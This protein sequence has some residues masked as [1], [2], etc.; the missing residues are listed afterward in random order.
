MQNVHPSESNKSLQQNGDDLLESALNKKIIDAEGYLAIVRLLIVAANIFAIALFFDQDNYKFWVVWP[1]IVVAS[2][3]STY[4]FVFKPY[5]RFEVLRSS[6]FATFSDGALITLLL[7]STGGAESP[8]FILW[9]I[10]LIAVAMRFSLKETVLTTLL[11]LCAD[12]AI[13]LLDTEKDLNIAALMVRFLYLPIFGVLGV[14]ISKEVHNQLNDKVKIAKTESDLK[15]VNDELEQRV[16]RRTHELEET[17]KDILDSITYAKR[18]QNAMLPSRAELKRSFK[19]CFVIYRPKDIISG[20]FYW[21]H[22]RIDLTIL[23]LVDCTGHGV[24]GALMA[25]MGN[26]LLD[27]IVKD[28]GITDPKETLKELDKAVSR[29]LK[30]EH[31]DLSINDGMVLSLCVFDKSKNLLH[32]AGA[33]QT[34]IIIQ[35]ETLEELK[36]TR[37]SIGGISES[38]QKEFES[39]TIP[40]KPGDRIYLFS[41]GFQDQFGGP[42][43][44]KFLRKNVKAMIEEIKEL[45]LSEQNEAIAK[46]L[47]RWK[48]DLAQVDDI[49]VIGI[50]I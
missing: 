5:L 25:M 43:G 44:K 16:H 4:V 8:F 39:T 46:S 15:R 34:G 27:S 1:T 12:L 48:G 9:F 13:V 30:S 6:Y 31:V 3:Y 47:I 18:I 35:D 14:Y 50:E 32:F 33:Q 40:I 7:Y 28:R 29:Q 45:P 38:N 19:D 2:I 37:H 22:D 20:D 21:I 49:T 10:S 24:P 36:S 23:A 42:R 41:D 26:N 17:N 11:Y